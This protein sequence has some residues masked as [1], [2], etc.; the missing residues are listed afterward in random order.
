MH[1]LLR[2]MIRINELLDNKLF[3][4]TDNVIAFKSIYYISK[5]EGLSL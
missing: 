1:P 2:K 3:W 5:L 4:C